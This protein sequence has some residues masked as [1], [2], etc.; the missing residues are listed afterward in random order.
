MTMNEYNKLRIFT[1]TTV[2]MGNNIL[3]ERHYSCSNC[4]YVFDAVRVKE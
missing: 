1:T 3:D 4:G 2:M